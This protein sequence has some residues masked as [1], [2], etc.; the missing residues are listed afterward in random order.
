MGKKRRAEKLRQNALDYTMIK[1]I[2]EISGVTVTI[3]NEW[4][5]HLRLRGERIWD[6]WPSTHRAWE[7]GTE[8]KAV[9]KVEPENIVSLALPSSLPPDSQEHLNAIS[10]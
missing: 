6:Y 1:A 2:A 8:M 7:Y 9:R 3:L 4:P 10:K 5:M